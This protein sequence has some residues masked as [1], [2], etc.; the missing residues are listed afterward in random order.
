MKLMKKTMK[1]LVAVFMM[2]M[3]FTATGITVSAADAK[4]FADTNLGS[5]AQKEI[6][7][8][9]IT[10]D[11]MN[12]LGFYSNSNIQQTDATKNSVTVSWYT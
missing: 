2:A 8:V 3:A 10:N 11:G 4:S 7:N 12:K 5:V 1:C 6:S 9:G